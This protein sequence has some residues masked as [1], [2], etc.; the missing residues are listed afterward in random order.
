MGPF[1][2][3]FLTG[4][5]N[6]SALFLVAAGLSLIF[7]VSRVVNMAHGSFYMVGAYVAYFAISW[8]PKGG[9]W[10]WGG[11]LIAAVV[12]GSVLIIP[13]FQG[14]P[15]KAMV[16]DFINELPALIEQYLGGRSII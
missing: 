3:Q 16:L 12:V 9:F 15:I 10:F 2:V 7:G 11:I 13:Q 1:I 4:L 8:L 6:A 5:S 14:S